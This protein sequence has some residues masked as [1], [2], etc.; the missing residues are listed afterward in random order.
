MFYSLPTYV[1][2]DILFPWAELLPP[3]YKDDN[4]KSQRDTCK[5]VIFL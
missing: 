1:V 5:G 2:M 3:Y 4:D